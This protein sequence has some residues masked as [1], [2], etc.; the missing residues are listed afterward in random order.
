MRRFLAILGLVAALQG[1]AYVQY[2]LEQFPRRTEDM[3]LD[4]I[5]R[6]HFITQIQL[7]GST[8]GLAITCAALVPF[9]FSL[10][11]CPV[12]AVAYNF[13][14]YEFILEPISRVLV[15]EGKPSLTGPYWERGARDGEKFIHE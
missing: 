11:V 6:E 5:R 9:P 3:W 7:E 10:F 2:A 14:V 1:C 12:V 8:A 15:K 4:P 13:G